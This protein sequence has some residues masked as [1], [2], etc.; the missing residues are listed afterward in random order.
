MRE[1]TAAQFKEW[2][3]KRSVEFRYQDVSTHGN[4]VGAMLSAGQYVA[5]DGR[6]AAQLVTYAG[7]KTRYYIAQWAEVSNEAR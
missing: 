5:T 1:A 3:D 6:L 4:A 2:L 7:G